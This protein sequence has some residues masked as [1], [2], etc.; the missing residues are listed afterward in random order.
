[1]KQILFSLLFLGNCLASPTVKPSEARL[2]EAAYAL[3][4]T[5]TPAAE[6]LLRKACTTEASA[7]IDYAL[8]NQLVTQQKST[9]AETAFLNALKKA[10]DF[11]AARNALAHLYLT[12]DQPQKA[13]EQL[14]KLLREDT[15][16]TQ[17]LM[18]IGHA[19][20]QQNRLVSAES[21]Y[22][23]L[24]LLSANHYEARRGLIQC[25]LQQQRY[26][27]CR[28]LLK[29]LMAKESKQELWGL[30]AD[31]A[32]AEEDYIAAT[33]ALETAHRLKLATPS[34]LARL[35]DLYLYRQMPTEAL[36]AYQG[37]AEKLTTQQRRHAAQSFL[38]SNQPQSAREMLVNM[39][40]SD[41]ETQRLLADCARLE[42]K[43]DEAITLYKQLLQH[44]PLN[45]AA[46]ISLADLQRSIAP[47][48]A[49]FNYERAARQKGFEAK[50]L[51][52]QAQLEAERNHFPKAIEL[53]VQAQTYDD[54]PDVDRYIKQLR[55]LAD[56]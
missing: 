13:I 31:L 56:K 20:L 1:M 49:L 23:Q 35:G 26:P 4:S 28:A 39:K 11:H 24:L 42:N 15:N 45:G 3:A 54:A 10:P 38:Q 34:M 18:L 5:N 25:L 52:R 22:R 36:G 48:K 40:D 53:V 19:Y 17:A 47:E 2:L 50:A 7:A 30:A 6:A 16:N 41:A 12:Q 32:L 14:S 8:G 55:A 51:L 9:D 27:E 43:P 33:S 37:I 21:A 44:D 29:E 46:L